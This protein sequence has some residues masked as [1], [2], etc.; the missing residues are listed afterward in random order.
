L[1]GSGSPTARRREL[2]VLLRS[3]RAEHGLTVDQV[4]ERLLCSPSKVSRME[5]GQ[6][7]VSARDIRD[8]SRIYGLD[9]ARRERLTELA[10]EGKQPAW[11]Q[12][13]ALRA[14]DY[15]GLEAEA[16][17]I[18]DFGLGLV[19]GL[20]QTPDYGREVMRIVLPRLSEDNTLEQRLEARMAR[21]HALVSK[22]RPDFEALLDE[23]VLHRVVGSRSVMR[24]QLSHLLEMS[25]HRNVTI[26]VL[27]FQRGALPSSNNKFIILTFDHPELPSTVF[28]ET[29]TEDLY[30]DRA[31]EVAGY[32]EVF[33]VMQAM[34]APVE[35][36]REM[37]AAAMAR[38]DTE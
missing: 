33:S 1:P 6:R 28:I 5:T 3:L 22:G 27:P 15:M 14:S 18:S 19:P 2:G 31:E 23:S 38:L 34:A 21:Q 20:L 35:Q 8:L 26:R 24:S 25:E 12:R 13:Q 32:Q 10:A 17:T 29:L 11:Y 16:K 9:D 37:I 30:L 7:G 36:T 4:A